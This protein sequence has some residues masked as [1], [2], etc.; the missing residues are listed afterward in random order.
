VEARV[1]P[2]S[3]VL[4]QNIQTIELRLGPVASV[5]C[6]KSEIGRFLNLWLCKIFILFGLDEAKSP[7][8]S[9]GLFVYLYFSEVGKLACQMV[10]LFA[11]SCRFPPQ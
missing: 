7:R 1:V 6:Q 10:A 2:L 11:G 8:G 4:V 3:C 5:V 9:P